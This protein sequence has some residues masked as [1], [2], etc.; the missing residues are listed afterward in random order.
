MGDGAGA[1]AKGVDTMKDTPSEAPVVSQSEQLAELAAASGDDAGA[2]GR[3]EAEPTRAEGS[4]ASFSGA[5]E[6]PKSTDSPASKRP[7]VLIV[8]G[9][10]GTGKTSL[11]QRL[12]AHLHEQGTPPYIINLDP[13]VT[14]MPYGPNIDIRDTVDYKNVMK[15]YKLG[16]N[17]GILTACNLFATRFD[18]V[19][20]RSLSSPGRVCLGF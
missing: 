11:M 15:Q 6:N 9:M 14:Y 13:A 5:S 2:T 7:T 18:Q 17:G 20:V 4:G 19:R 10:A 8:I 16:P 3:V 12:N 1:T